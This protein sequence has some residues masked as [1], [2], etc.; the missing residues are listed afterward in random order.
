MSDVLNKNSQQQLNS[1]CISVG[2]IPSG[3]TGINIIM[4]DNNVEDTIQIFTRSGKHLA[5][6][7]LADLFITT[8]ITESTLINEANGFSPGSSYV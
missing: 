1:C 6:I 5:G 7:Q 2:I 3:S 8:P 4:N